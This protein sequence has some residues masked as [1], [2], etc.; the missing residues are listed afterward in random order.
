MQWV[1]KQIDREP[2][3]A[4]MRKYH[5]DALTA[6]IL[7]RRNL[8]NGENV[9]YMLETNSRYLYSPFLFD[10]MEDA[11]DR[12]LNAKDEG[13]KVLVFGDRDVDGIT[14]T[15]LL[16]EALRDFGLDVSWQIPTGDE[17]YG[18]SKEAIDNFAQKDG[19]LII[20]VD[21]G[22]S[23]F[24]EIEYAC[25]KSI[26]VIITDHHKP[27]EKLPNAFTII[28]PQLEDSGYPMKE[29]SGCAV[30]W[31]LVL[32]L[33]FAM[34]EFYKHSI[35]L[36]NVRPI[37]NAYTVE[38]RKMINLVEVASLQ[39]HI[40][41]GAVSFS[42]TR[43]PQFLQGQQI[44]VWNE[45][46]QK[47]MLDRIFGTGIEFNFCDLQPL[48]AQRYPELGTSSLLRLKD[49]STIGKYF[50]ERNTEIDAFANI[51]ITFVQA[52]NKLFSNR[53]L[54]EIQLVSVSTI[55]DLMPLR[56][57]NRMLLRLG[58]KEMNAHLRSGLADI[59]ARQGMGAQKI[60]THEIGWSISPV[61][62]AAGRM[63]E[64]E[65]AVQ[66][67]TAKDASERNTL[68]D[69]LFR[70]NEERKTL[71][72]TCWN[73]I[74]NESYKS[75]DEYNQK[76]VVVASDKIN[77][78]VSGILASRLV[79]TFNVPCIVI[80]KMPDG[81]ATASCRSVKGFQILD[82]LTPSKELF[83]DYGG[84]DYAA[85]FSIK[86][87]NLDAFLQELKKT[88]AV[89]EFAPPANKAVEID[90]E[91][92]EQYLK[93]ELLETLDTFEPFGEG[94]P[95]LVFM[96]EGLR[97]EDASLV[98]RGEK[99]HLKLILK[100]GDTK[101]TALFW[102]EG[103][104]LEQ[105]RAWSHVDLAYTIQRNYYNGNVTPQMIVIDLQPHLK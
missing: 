65:V 33:R 104:R 61:L 60:G 46:S 55:A 59:L 48:V 6:S 98:G 13:E 27:Q 19:T 94:F 92:P 24:N 8:V 79:N 39:E 80:C 76:L 32:A 85:G 51:F 12:I 11:V 22:I 30:A 47:K 62:N 101:W 102:G 10:N 87:E 18:L 99:K 5:C 49:F 66:M 68:V 95:E 15:A 58:L 43:L 70:M 74:I 97:L 7:V 21:C 34:T 69:K 52:T 44:F 90:A 36:L 89:I 91:L 93:P 64:A 3:K 40:Q 38:V 9:L 105:V 25:E 86:A 73:E 35:C 37:N 78:G 81:T 17:T 14:S 56:S 84:H 1:K 16:Y 103:E 42:A 41:E 77:R 26:D 53:E 72:E 75:F 29:I 88:S 57:E 83:I 20:T 54:Q 28:N 50:E 4:M 2:V 31:K 67:L 23:N 82:L 45:T 71:S 100:C 96:S 63:G